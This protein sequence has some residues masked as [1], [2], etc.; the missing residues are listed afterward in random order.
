MSAVVATIRALEATLKDAFATSKAKVIVGPGVT[1][2]PGEHGFVFLGVSDPDE[3]AYSEAAVASQSWAQLGGRV[4]DETF[5]VHCAAV[6]W[7]GAG[8]IYRAMDDAYGLMAAVEAALVADPSLGSVLLFAPGITAHS[9]RLV[10]D[11]H[12]AGAQVPFDVTCRAR[13]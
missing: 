3:S 7:N 4:R 2:D 12:G 9:L 1:D 6:A 10:Q 13:I 8:D 11:E 5:S